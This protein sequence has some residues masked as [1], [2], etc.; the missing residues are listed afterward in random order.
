MSIYTIEDFGFSIFESEANDIKDV[1]GK[2]PPTNAISGNKCEVNDANVEYFSKYG[3][4]TVCKMDNTDKN[5]CQPCQAKIF[6]EK[7][8]KWSS[9]NYQIN[10]II[11]SSQRKATKNGGFFEWIPFHKFSNIQK[12]GKGGFA[13]VYKATWYN[14]RFCY[15]NL[16]TKEAFRVG[17]PST[18][19]ALK[20]YDKLTDL[21]AELE[22][23]DNNRNLKTLPCYGVTRG[24]ILD[25]NS[26]VLQFF[27][28][29][30]VVHCLKCRSKFYQPK[31]ADL[32]DHIALDCPEQ[33]KDIIQL[34]NQ[35]RIE[36]YNSGVWQY[37]KE[38]QCEDGFRLIYCLKCDWNSYEPKT[39]DLE[40]HMALNCP[41][42]EKDVIRF[43]SEGQTEKYLLVLDLAECD[44]RTYI[45]DNFVRI[46]WVQRIGLVKYLAQD[47]KEMHERKLVHQ[48]LHPGNE[49]VDIIEGWL[50]YGDEAINPE[51]RDQFDVA[52]EIRQK[53][54]SSYRA[55]AKTH[56]LAIYSSQTLPTKFLKEILE[57]DDTPMTDQNK[58]EKWFEVK[59]KRGNIKEI[60]LE[61]FKGLPQENK[62]KGGMRSLRIA[63]RGP[64]KVVI[65]NTNTRV[66]NQSVRFRHFIYEIFLHYQ[67]SGSENVIQ[68][69]GF[70]RDNGE[71]L[72]VMEWADDGNL[73]E[74]IDHK[75][76][77]LEW[78]AKIKLA[79]GI[80][81]G[82]KC[83]HDN[84][85]L[86][87]DL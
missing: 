59:K 84:H 35:K 48:D 52:E 41:N 29:N 55:E 62:M 1:I 73:E 70:T 51:F 36:K 67:C 57:M 28:G 46:T 75:F 24:D 78:A 47:I 12:I 42:Q 33:E 77:S 17:S 82:I 76:Q 86:H 30:Y 58:W 37:F 71:H 21:L 14:S 53:L 27:D 9:G 81:A 66:P 25:N 20:S 40:E 49:I 43:Y 80:A 60:L 72:V 74:Y 54:A 39:G 50:E 4:C 85:I 22:A 26:D 8:C 65:K 38:I 32:E 11:R 15:W 5:Y 10:E 34:Y 23:Y 2:S 87:R 45:S 31:S 61:D 3:K 63:N 69:L 56:Q 44:L 18:D 68:L 19:V 64:I 16:V 13:S 6:E 7:F 79:K 83:L